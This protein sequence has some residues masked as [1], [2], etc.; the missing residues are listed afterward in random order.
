MLPLRFTNKQVVSCSYMACA[1][2]VRGS[3]NAALIALIN[4]CGFALISNLKA[5]L[6]SATLHAGRSPATRS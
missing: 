4:G 6:R 5:S 2:T 1:G 3:D